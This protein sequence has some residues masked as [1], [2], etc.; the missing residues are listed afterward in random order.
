[1]EI[2]RKGIVFQDGA[3]K[4]WSFRVVYKN[5]A[6]KVIDKRT[7]GIK[8]K[9]EAKLKL[10]E[11]EI[12]NNLSEKG[13]FEKYIDKAQDRLN[14]DVLNITLGFL[15]EQYIEYSRNRLKSSSLKSATDCLRK[16]VLGYFGEK[17]DVGKIKTANILSWQ[18]EIV[19]KG[20]SF[21][22]CSKIYCAFTA[23]LNFGVKYYEIPYNVAERVGN[24]KNTKP[25][26]E[27]NFWTLEEFMQ[28][29]KINDDS[30]Y[31]LFFTLLYFTGM[32]KGE[33]IALTW[34]DVN[35]STKELL[36]SKSVNR[37]LPENIERCE[38]CVGETNSSIGWHFVGNRV[39]EITSTKTTS[40]NRRVLLSDNVYNFLIEHYNSVRMCYGFNENWFVF[41]GE[42]PF[43]DQT[44]RR[45][46]NE[47]ADKAQVKR[48]RVHD[49]RH[50]HASLLINKGHNILIVAKRLGHSDI[51]QTLNT[52][53][54]L[55]PNVQN[56][57]INAI[58]IK[59]D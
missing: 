56:E 53:S 42:M 6:G 31:K 47:M 57:I 26:K 28:F 13:A 35:F 52:Y 10:L 29:Y 49:L 23:L 33:C 51:K 27:M 17:T 1:M 30:E 8:T 43:S 58:N 7:S 44:I 15:F 3:T 21:K 14:G 59:L 22:Y 5:D 4:K 45:K 39:Y 34:K 50:S 2:V 18:N 38:V 19:G 12:E 9:K 24:F 37:K 41:G 36:I 48:I 46:M 11:Y 20:F 25:K 55:M 32:R 40:S 54:H 16:Y